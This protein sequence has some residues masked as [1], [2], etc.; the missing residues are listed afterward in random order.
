MILN[1]RDIAI[2]YFSRSAQAEVR[3]R[4]WELELGYKFAFKALRHLIQ[5]SK[6]IAQ[7]TDYPVFHINERNQIG[8]NFEERF[9][10]AIESIFQKRVSKSNC[11]W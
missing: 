2:L 4:K 8:A 11:H 1:N 9:T 7:S 6:K 5:H 3:A 10:N